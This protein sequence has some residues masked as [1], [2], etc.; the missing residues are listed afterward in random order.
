MPEKFTTK[1]YSNGLKQFQLA[2]E[3]PA[4]APDTEGDRRHSPPRKN[5]GA[6]IINRLEIKLKE[7][8]YCHQGYILSR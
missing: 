5:V 1:I 7:T 8:G 3:Q 6:E 2:F 4:Q